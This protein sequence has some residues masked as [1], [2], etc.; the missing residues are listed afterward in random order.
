MEYNDTF[1]LFFSTRKL[2]NANY[3]SLIYKGAGKYVC[4]L[5]LYTD[6]SQDEHCIIFNAVILRQNP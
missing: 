6:F 5:L 2:L 3:S 1:F 4:F